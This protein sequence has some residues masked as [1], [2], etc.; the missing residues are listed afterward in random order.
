MKNS[1]KRPLVFAVL[2]RVST[3]DQKDGHSLDMQ[4]EFGR[5]YAIKQ[6]ATDVLEYTGVESATGDQRD[7][8]DAALADAEAGKYV[9]LVVQDLTRLSRNP[10]VM[11]AAMSRLRKA[12]IV[13]HD[14]N[15]P[16]PLETPEGEFRVMIESVVGRFTARQS[17]QKSLSARV[18]ILKSGGIAAGRPPAGRKWNK[19]KQKLEIDPDGKQLMKD[20]YRLIVR[21]K[22]SLNQAARDLKIAPS[23]LRKAIAQSALTEISQRL[24]GHTANIPCP[25][26]LTPEQQREIEQRLD[27]NKIIRPKTK[28]Q[29][30]LQ[31]LVRCAHCG[32]TM[33]GQTSTKDGKT[34]PVYRH[35]PKSYKSGCVWQVPVKLLDEDI[36]TVC[37]DTIADSDSLRRAIEAA[38]ANKNSENVD[39]HERLNQINQEVKLSSSR[40]DKLI[41]RIALFDEGTETL[42]RLKARATREDLNLAQLKLDRDELVRQVTLIGISGTAIEDILAKVRTLY[43]RRGAAHEKLM[44]FEK[45]KDFVQAIVGKPTSRDKSNGIFVR[46]IRAKGAS[47]KDVKWAYNL[48]GDLAIASNK[49]NRDGN[50]LPEL[51]EIRAHSDKQVNA[52]ATIAKGSLGVKP[53]H[54]QSGKK[55]SSGD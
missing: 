12:G 33:T 13:L 38:V 40:L 29:Y 7:I 48:I 2:A 52:L 17:V 32:A 37:A 25:P 19:S 18:R 35:P 16:I 36:L 41:D 55:C 20:A 46:M 1:N 27:E 11:F 42:K 6:G 15:G 10:A 21:N 47:K 24:A 26:L 28:G 34:Y 9:V 23:S 3:R 4:V 5:A 30:L 54:M 50:I 14:L 8:L 31:G 43:W 51:I 44:T 45:R 39:I 53:R 22:I 49:L